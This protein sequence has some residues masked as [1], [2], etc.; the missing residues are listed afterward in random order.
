M[1]HAVSTWIIGDNFIFLLN[2]CGKWIGKKKEYV[3]FQFNTALLVL[4][5]TFNNELTTSNTII[6][7][8]LTTD[9]GLEL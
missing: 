6:K 4:L 5:F 2:I 1:S 9:K 7:T 3:S 8:Y